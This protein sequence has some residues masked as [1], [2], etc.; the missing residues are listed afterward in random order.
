MET[1]AEVCNRALKN[2][3]E[4][5]EAQANKEIQEEKS[6]TSQNSEHPPCSE[7][8]AVNVRHDFKVF[9]RIH[10]E[11]CPDCEC[12]EKARKIKEQEER[13]RDRES[14]IKRHI[15]SKFHNCK[16]DTF[17]P[18]DKK[19]EK[20]FN[21]IKAVP[22]GSF[23]IHGSYG[24]GKTHLMTAQFRQCY[25]KEICYLRTTSELVHEIRKDETSDYYTSPIM[26][27]LR[28]KKH[29]HLFWDDADKIKVTEFK[30]EAIFE[31][32]D[33]IYRHE[34]GLSVTSNDNLQ[35]LQSKLSP[36]TVRRIDD[37]CKVIEV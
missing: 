10:T 2:L 15:P 24:S 37:V 32:I 4:N 8:G 36:A 7:C 21:E 30:L 19:Q 22:L 6:S 29:F 18:R 26:N 12:A 14:E 1:G 11:W 25:H 27:N 20:A 28:D 33:G 34:M 5:Q 23:Y 3:L 9:D 35:E 13:E 16:L 17:I 31:L